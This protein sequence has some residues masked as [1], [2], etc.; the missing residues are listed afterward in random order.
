MQ[1]PD[2]P[3]ATARQLCVSVLK[4]AEANNKPERYGVPIPEQWPGRGNGACGQRMF[5]HG[6]NKWIAAAL[7]VNG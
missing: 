2:E 1:D 5:F 6:L 7:N 3:I 4:E